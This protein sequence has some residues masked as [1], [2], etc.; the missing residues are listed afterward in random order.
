MSPTRFASALAAVLAVTAVTAPASADPGARA[1]NLGLSSITGGVQ[2]EE[3]A[4]SDG[5][6]QS[7]AY[8]ATPAGYHTHD[9]FYLRLLAGPSAVAGV[10]NDDLDTSVS[11]VGGAFHIAAGTAL[12]PNLIIY[13]ELF[14]NTALSPTVESG[15]LEVETSDDTAFSL[16]GIGPGLAIYLPGNFYLS[17]T[18]AFSRLVLD[19]DTEQDDDEA[20]TD[21]GVTLTAAIGKEWW[22][23][24]NWGLGAALQLYGGAMKDGDAVNEDGEDTVWGAGG[25]LLA[26]SATLN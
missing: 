20:T 15:E 3:I 16:V 23:S 12:V 9:G 21:L 10:A 24:S 1:I 22:V 13:G 8:M 26:F 5:E 11:G 7:E 19:P 6:Y 14:V 2:G 4:P 18:L 17:S 25:I